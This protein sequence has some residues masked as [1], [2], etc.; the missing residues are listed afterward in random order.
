MTIVMESAASQDAA[1]NADPAS[2]KVETNTVPAEAT[3]AEATPAEKA[4]Y[5]RA[6]TTTLS[7]QKNW[8][9]IVGSLSS[10]E[11]SDAE[12]VPNEYSIKK[13]TQRVSELL[14]GLIP[15]LDTSLAGA[16]PRGTNTA[17][18]FRQQ[19]EETVKQLKQRQSEKQ[20]E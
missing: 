7:F 15:G 8:D 12:D 5:G 11:S 6:A 1:T 19:L 14:H 18:T 4:T 13:N 17:N 10:P 16:P 20:Q 9:R 2:E 3:R